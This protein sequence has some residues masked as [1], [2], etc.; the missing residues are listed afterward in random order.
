MQFFKYYTLWVITM[1]SFLGKITF[2]IIVCLVLVCSA[3]YAATEYT[4]GDY[5]YVLSGKNATITA[6]SGAGEGE[7]AIPSSL[8]GHTVTAIYVEAFA[9]CTK[10]TKVTVPDTVTSIAVGAFKGCTSLEEMTLP[11]IGSY[12]GAENVESA[13]FGYIFGSGG[14]NPTRQYYKNKNYMDCAIPQ[15]LKK[16]TIL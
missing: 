11:F 16:V 6:Y 2:L 5:T 12:K 15:S 3:A 13:L 1:K 9:D 14:E 10:L 7:L 8:G 4:D